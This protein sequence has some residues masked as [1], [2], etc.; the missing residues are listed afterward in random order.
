[1]AFLLSSTTIKRPNS[2][3]ESNSTQQAENRTL[4]GS[5]SR[6]QF[7]SNKRIWELEYE[8]CNKTDY[9]TI[10]TIYDSYLSTGSTKTWQVTETNYTIAQT[11]VHVDLLVREFKVQ[12]SSFIS[13]FTLTLREA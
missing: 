4:S 6:D 7:G 9:D 1:M 2:M 12:G 13:D 5:V 3:E 11:N 8:N 10:K